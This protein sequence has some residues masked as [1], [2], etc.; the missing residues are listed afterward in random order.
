MKRTSFRKYFNRT[1]KYQ[2][3]GETVEF[4]LLIFPFLVFC[5]IVIDMS[6]LI[7]D[8]QILNHAARYSARQG[9][10]FWIDPDNYYLDGETNIPDK[11][12]SINE[13]MITSSLDYFASFMIRKSIKDPEIN[14]T[15]EDEVEGEEPNRI[16]RDISNST[17]SISLENEHY[18]FT[19]G[20]FLHLKDK[21]V[22]LRGSVGYIDSDEQHQ[23][24]STEADIK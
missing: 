7:F 3:G 1:R 23:G 8:Q 5:F 4:A 2:V 24:I 22:N 13:K 16:W 14:I 15:A 21:F 19:I 20:E 10:L 17:V 18:Y 12:I 6:V 11:Q 9:T